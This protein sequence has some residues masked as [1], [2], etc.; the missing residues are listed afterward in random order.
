MTRHSYTDLVVQYD[1]RAPASFPGKKGYDRLLYACKHVLDQPIA[2]LF[3][4]QSSSELPIE[5]LLI[6]PELAMANQYS[7]PDP[8]PLLKHFPTKYT[9]APSVEEDLK[10]E[11]PILKIPESANS[12]D[13]QLE[14]EDFATGIYEWLSLL[15]LS[16]PRVESGD[17]IDPFLSRYSVPCSSGEAEAVKLCKISWRGFIAPGWARQTLVDVILSVSSRSWFSLSVASFGK[18]VRGEGSECTI[19][20]LP[21][22][23]GEY[24][25]WDIHDHE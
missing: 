16:S 6:L 12:N 9:S 10:I 11:T 2:W 4:R 25:L 24:L 23:P 18:G 21:D 3:H 5:F 1:L 14:L 17:E 22:A 13:A 15:K 8:D 7:A 19:L 20:R